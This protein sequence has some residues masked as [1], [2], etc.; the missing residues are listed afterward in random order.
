MTVP[1][2]TTAKHSPAAS[3]A[4]THIKARPALP[5]GAVYQADG[6]VFV[7]LEYPVT[8]RRLVSGAEQSDTVSSVV[9]HR[10]KGRA[11]TSIL[12]MEGNGSQT[13]A[14]IEA[15]LQMTGPVADALL[16]EVDAED[17]LKLTTV[18]SVFFGSGKKK[19]GR[20][21]SQP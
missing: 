6:S 15:C 12:D 14:M 10:I 20:S 4:D 3:G 8:Q 9:M 19:T 2:V 21:T 5:E 17:Y 7:P 1:S 11:M 18:A 13:R 16:D